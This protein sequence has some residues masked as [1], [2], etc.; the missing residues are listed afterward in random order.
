MQPDV[1]GVFDDFPVLF[2]G[3][4]PVVSSPFLFHVY[5]IDALQTC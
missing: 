5:V 2:I 3:D 4:R 1:M